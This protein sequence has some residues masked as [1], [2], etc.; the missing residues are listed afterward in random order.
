MP[1]WG[2][3]APSWK[4]AL[5]RILKLGSKGSLSGFWRPIC[6]RMSCD[7]RRAASVARLFDLCCRSRVPSL[8]LIPERRFDITG[9]KLGRIE[10]DVGARAAK[11]F[12]PVADDVAVLN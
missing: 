8:F 5:R 3:C 4:D 11:L 12:E 10:N 7:N 1:W 6:K 2:R 9:F